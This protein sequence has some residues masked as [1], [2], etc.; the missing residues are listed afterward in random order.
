MPCTRGNN[1]RGSLRSAQDRRTAGR[2]RHRRGTTSATETFARIIS[3]D[4]K[5]RLRPGWT[6]NDKL[7][8][9]PGYRDENSSKTSDVNASLPSGAMLYGM[10][11]EGGS[12]NLGVIFAPDLPSRA[13]AFD[14]TESR[15]YRDVRAGSEN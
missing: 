12:D 5:E 10:T 1:G 15:L 9:R 11:S 8:G 3:V 13:Q 4:S 6:D 2:F 14:S 7:A